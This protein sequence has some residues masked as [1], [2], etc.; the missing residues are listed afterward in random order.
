[1]WN[2]FFQKPKPRADRKEEPSKRV[3]VKE[4]F[5]VELPYDF[6]HGDRP[7][8]SQDEHKGIGSLRH[9]FPAILRGIP[10]LNSANPDDLFPAYYAYRMGKLS[11][12]INYI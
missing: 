4:K 2:N 12:I 1:M 11:G 3:D 6:E 8:M 10:D 9:F 5:I 7:I